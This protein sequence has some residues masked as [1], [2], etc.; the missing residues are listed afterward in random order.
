MAERTSRLG[1]FQQCHVWYKEKAKSRYH[2]SIVIVTQNRRLADRKQQD[3]H[4]YEWGQ[5]LRTLFYRKMIWHFSFVEVI[6]VFANEHLI[7]ILI[8]WLLSEK[9]ICNFLAIW[10]YFFSLSLSLSLLS[11]SAFFVLLE[12]W[13]KPMMVTPAWK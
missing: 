12:V 11:V 9:C 3:Q 8:T 2:C 6:H 4:E 7:C 5:K 13:I 1:Y 10:Y